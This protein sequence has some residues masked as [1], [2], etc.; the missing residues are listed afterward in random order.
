M[1]W[2]RLSAETW[3]VGGALLLVAGAV[4]A[5]SLLRFTTT[6]P[7]YCLGCHATGETL[8][9]GAGSLIHPPYGRVACVDCHADPARTVAGLHVAAEGYR[10]GFSA[11]PERLN[12]N[13]LRCHGDVMGREIR[14]FKFNL[15]GVRIPHAFH[16]KTVGARCTDC[17]SNIAHEKAAPATNR[18]HMEACIAC[19][20]GDAK[21]STCWKCHAK[22]SLSLPRSPLVTPGTCARCHPD[23]REKPHTTFGLKFSHGRHLGQGLPCQTCHSNV[24]RHGGLR[25]SREG[26]MGCHHRTRGARCADCHAAQVALFRGEGEAALMGPAPPSMMAGKVACTGCHDFTKGPATESVANRCAACHGGAYAQI[27]E[28]WKAGV[29]EQLER[30]AQI[31]RRTEKAVAARRRGGGEVRMAQ[32]QLEE[33][34]RM[35]TF[36]REARGIHNP[37][38]AEA[39][40]SR[41]IEE[42]DQAGPSGG[43]AAA[44]PRGEP[45][46]QGPPEEFQ[47]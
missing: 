12:Q 16:L 25:I 37:G 5:V 36:V 35:I 29:A 9:V 32:R 41:A 3:L 17:H 11:Q 1:R 24:E 13:C 15:M 43:G 7:E 8:N 33:G 26:C 40:L 31:L 30:A 14:Q 44:V 20:Q 39:L 19:H 34:R 10:G 47:K 46:R 23:F 21:A 4:P 18:P 2:P 28:I 42:L 45:L 22:G 6:S 27:M 38:L